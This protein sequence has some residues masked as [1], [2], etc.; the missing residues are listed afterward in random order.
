MN[1]ELERY[2]HMYRENAILHGEASQNGD[3]KS[4]NKS[5]DII[6]KTLYKIRELDD[7]GND[8]LLTLTDDKDA[9]VRVWA[10]THSLEY[11]TIKAEK[12]LSQL[13]SCEGIIALGAEITLSEW[14]AGTL[15][16]P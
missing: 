13:A 4:A 11:D 9:S 3:Y 10:A 6:I 8:A 5:H 7:V 2:I 12:T 15:E 1:V 14:K 16:L